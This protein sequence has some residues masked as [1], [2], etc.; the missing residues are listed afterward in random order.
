MKD[1]E[2][3]HLKFL[4]GARTVTGSKTLLEVGDTK[5]LVDCGLFQ[6]LKELRRLNWEN[7]TRDASQIDYVLLT[8][9]HLD[10]C[11][12]LPI[13]VKNGFKGTIYCTHPTK[14]LAAIVLKDSGKIQEEDANRANR[15]S[16]TSH[17][18]AKPLY[19]Q[20]HAEAV[21]K[22]FST[23]NY[24]EW[25]ILAPEIKFQFL[26]AGHILGSAM[27]ELK[28][29]GRTFVFS[30]DIGRT[31][32]MLLYPPK[33][34]P[35]ADYLIIESTYGDR[36]HDDSDIKLELARIIKDTY[37]RGGILMVPTFSIERVQE[38]MFL[39]YQLRNE[40]KM[41]NIPVY[42]DSPMGIRATEVF[43]DYPQ[44]Q[45]LSRN[46][47][48]RMYE[49]IHW[50]NTYEASKAIVRD[51]SSKIVLAGSGMLQG[52]RI[53]H[54]LSAHMGN[55]NN[56][57]LFTG[58]QA[59]GTRGRS[60]LRGSS[61]IKFF[62]EY[63]SVKCQIASISSLSAHGDRAELIEWMKHFKTPPK[64]VFLN[65]GEPHQLDAFRVL[66]QS[67]LGWDVIIPYQEESFEL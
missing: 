9:A 35:N 16:Y 58:Y 45:D 18:P 17:S 11:G 64:K 6:G 23:H 22:H 8:H 43:E 44:W 48:N 21:L 49:G 56:T 25:V 53:L 59:E 42:L 32:P 31:D 39:L 5:I 1:Q 37:K 54:Y 63:H 13:L 55:E 41:P 61:S 12:Y 65:H 24:D 47:L 4:G 60:I 57:L 40:D 50:V 7:I 14:E 36:E 29:H 19:T 30:G 38:I 20:D 62:G 66:I 52:G 51:K 33:K 2:K 10:H 27:I 26:N 67:K 46:D 15:H 3:I 28:L 34:V